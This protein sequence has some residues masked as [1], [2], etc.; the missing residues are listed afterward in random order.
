MRMTD[1]QTIAIYRVRDLPDSRPTARSTRR[2]RG[3]LK[4]PRDPH[5]AAAGR[6]PDDPTDGRDRR[7]L[8]VQIEAT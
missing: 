1:D 8:S 6:R 7:S 4:T 3:N 2:L 5:V